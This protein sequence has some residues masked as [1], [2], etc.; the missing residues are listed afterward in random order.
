MQLMWH[1]RRIVL[2]ASLS[3]TAGIWLTIFP[4]LLSDLV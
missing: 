3:S 4:E 1:L 2:S